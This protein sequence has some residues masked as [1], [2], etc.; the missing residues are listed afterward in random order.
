MTTPTPGARAAELRRQLLVLVPLFFLYHFGLLLAPRATNGVDLF[1]RLAAQLLH[2]STPLYLLLLGLL[3]GAYLLWLRSMPGRRFIDSRRLGL[4]LAESVL[5]AAFMGPLAA[6]LLHKLHLLGTVP[7]LLGPIEKVVASA[8]AG[9]YEELVFRLGAIW[10]ILRLLQGRQRHKWLHLP[11]A[12]LL[13][14]LAFS[15]AHYLGP[16]SEPFLWASF[17][18]RLVLGLVLGV[19]FLWRGL[20]TAAYSHFLYDLFVLFLGP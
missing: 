10:L 13:S 20:D 1:T 15:A 9:L 12:L 7:S 14:S 18:F 3:M 5:Y 6:L 4:T 16:G 8:G 2:H 19:I 11:L 17:T